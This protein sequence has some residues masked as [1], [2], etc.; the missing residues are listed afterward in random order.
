VDGGFAVGE[1]SMQIEAL[2]RKLMDSQVYFERKGSALCAASAIEMA[3]W[4]IKG[5]TL[6]VPVYEL[7]GGEYR[8]EIEVYASDCYWEE[9]PQNMANHVKKLVERGIK[10]VRAHIGACPPREDIL[11]VEVLT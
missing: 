8:E 6:N 10:A 9:D 5:K 1:N 3:C 11:R 7:L 2:L 4:D